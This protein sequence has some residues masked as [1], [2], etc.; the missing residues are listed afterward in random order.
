MP[1]DPK[2][3]QD[4]PQQPVNRGRGRPKGSKDSKPRRKPVKLRSSGQDRP[5]YKPEPTP[6]DVPAPTEQQHI[7]RI[8]RVSEKQ[9]DQ[10]TQQLLKQLKRY[11]AE[12]FAEL[13]E[14][15]EAAGQHHL[16]PA[17]QTVLRAICG[18]PVFR[19]PNGQNH[20]ST[21][22]WW[23]EMWMGKP[24]QRRDVNERREV[25]IKR[26]PV[27]EVMNVSE[28]DCSSTVHITDEVEA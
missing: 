12:D 28:V 24:M 15:L 7:P 5:K 4:P 19:E 8:R 1:D 27:V 6:P 21:S 3:S 16:I 23:L 13:F 18:D 17:V 25:V 11:H 26:E 10:A 20:V 22:M 14:H 2:S 9:S